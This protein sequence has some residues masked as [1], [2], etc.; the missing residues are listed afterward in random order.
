MA[1][2]GDFGEVIR[3]PCRLA[4]GD[5]QERHQNGR[6]ISWRSPLLLRARTALENWPAFSAF[7]FGK[8]VKGDPAIT[9]IVVTQQLRAVSAI[10]GVYGVQPWPS[11]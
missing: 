4:K 9:M 3:G 10:E 7:E 2:F 1:Q 6:R 11:A 8:P 5:C